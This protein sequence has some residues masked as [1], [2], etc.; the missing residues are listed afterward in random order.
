MAKIIKEFAQKHFFKHDR[1]NRNESGIKKF[2]EECFIEI[3]QI[4]ELDT[5]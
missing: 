4:Q 5:Y 1:P 2:F 3:G